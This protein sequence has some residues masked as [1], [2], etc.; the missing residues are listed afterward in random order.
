MRAEGFGGG[1]AEVL[2]AEESLLAVGFEDFLLLVK[3]GV[4]KWGV[5]RLVKRERD[6]R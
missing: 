3:E 2:G 6:I 5:C 1:V 4:S